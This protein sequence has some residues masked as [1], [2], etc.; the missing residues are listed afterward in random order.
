MKL[1]GVPLLF[2]GLI[3]IAIGLFSII[4]GFMP[5]GI[6]EFGIKGSEVRREA[7]PIIFWINILFV[8]GLGV[9]F[10]SIGMRFM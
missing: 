8:V 9:L 2:F 5:R 4:K 10:V 6:D 3:W 1:M 7:N